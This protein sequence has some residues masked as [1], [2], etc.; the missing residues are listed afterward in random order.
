MNEYS[1]HSEHLLKILEHWLLYCHISTSM[2]GR[3]W[4][5]GSF[6]CIRLPNKSY[7]LGMYTAEYKTKDSV[8]HEIYR[9]VYDEVY[10]AVKMVEKYECDKVV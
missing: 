7:P 6:S 1:E 5:R 2:R 9:R 4:S 3:L 10:K 8:V